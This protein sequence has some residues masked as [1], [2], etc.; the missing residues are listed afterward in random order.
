MRSEHP[1]AG[2]AADR[3]SVATILKFPKG[4][5]ARTSSG[6]AASGRAASRTKR[7]A[8]TPASRALSVASTE[9]HHSSGI[10]SLWDHLRTAVAGAPR[11]VA[12]APSEGH[13]EMTSLNEFG[14]VSIESSIGQ[15][16]PNIKDVVSTDW[17]YRSRHHVGMDMDDDDRLA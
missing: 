5:H 8:V 2:R 17:G 11:S 12:I 15:I 9:D 6:R 16:V 10:R 1:A 4:G 7:S 14:S 3:K 13:S